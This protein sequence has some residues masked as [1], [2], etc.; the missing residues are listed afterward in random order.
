M[1]KT[2]QILGLAIALAGLSGQALANGGYHGG[3]HGSRHG[4]NHHH[5][6][7]HHNHFS[8]SNWV[9]PLVALGV[10]GAVIS[11]TSRPAPTYV[12]PSVTY[13]PPQPAPSASYFCGSSGQFYPYTS[14]CP[15]GW[16]LVQSGYR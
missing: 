10:A 15:E 8:G 16:Q 5:H 2:L 13:Y 7:R 4:W 14:Y 6:H 12:E 3:H 11:A 1:K 9:A